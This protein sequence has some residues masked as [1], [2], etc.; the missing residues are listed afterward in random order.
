NFRWIASRVTTS[1][2]R[3]TR[4][5]SRSRAC[6]L[7][8]TGCPPAFRLPRTSSNSNSPNALSTYGFYAWGESLRGPDVTDLRIFEL[9][10]R[11]HD[12]SI[13]DAMRTPTIRLPRPALWALVLLLMAIFV[14]AG[15]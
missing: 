13:R 5:Q 10:R 6:P 14:R 11:D 2:G 7:S 15:T 9:F 1:P 4:R 12:A 8:R 3:S